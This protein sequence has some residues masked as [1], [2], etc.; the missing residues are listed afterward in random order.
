VKYFITGGAG[1][2]GSNM[3]DRL[4]N[5]ND[6]EVT[7]YDNFCSGKMSYIE[8]HLKDK[9]FRL[10]KGDMLDLP[11]L[12]KSIKG[13]D[14][15]FHFA[16]N[17]DIAKSMLETDLD[18]RLGII[19]T[20]NV[21]ESMRTTGVKMLAY[22]SGSGVYGDVGPT[23]TAENFGPLLPVSMY[24]ASKLG[25]EGVISAFCGMFDLQA[26][27]FRFANVVGPRQ[28]HG[29]GFDF[30]RKLKRE[31]HKLK[32][33]GDGSQSKSYIHVI[34]VID[35]MLYVIKKQR[36][37][38]NVFNVATDDY[39]T[40]NEIAEIVTEE[41]KLLD[42]KFEHTSGSRGWKGDVPVV[43]F[44]IEKIHKLGWKSKYS[45]RQ[46]IQLSIQALLKEL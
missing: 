35:A 22:S 15:V 29:V 19:A 37:S 40:V 21:V 17:P 45:S 38:M 7:V 31:P 6:N 2:I 5:D 20:Y 30:I 34:D 14:F 8:H 13:H 18:L 41:I 11:L 46:A 42:V 25:A 26:W 9:R 24:G 23:Q 36:Q 4:L 44:D 16:A 33:L 10:I 3:T 43:R 12:K 28:T 32:I 39:I 27:I 1:F